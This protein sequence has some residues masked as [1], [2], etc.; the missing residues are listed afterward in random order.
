[1]K[2]KQWETKQLDDVA[3]FSSGGTPSKEEPNYWEGDYP[4]ISAKDMKS[5][6]IKD[7]GLKLTHEGLAVAKI[8]KKGSVLVL[9]RGMTLLK[10]LPV[11]YVERDVAFNQDI[12]ALVAK[13]GVSGLF[14][15][16]ALIANKNRILNLVN[17]AGHGTGRLDTT[18]LKEFPIDLPPLLEQCR[19]AEVLGVWDESIDLL[20]RLIGR[21]R[22]RKQGL[23]QQLLT[24]KN[25]VNILTAKESQFFG[26]IQIHWEEKNFS[27]V[28]ELVSRKNSIKVPNVLT[29]SSKNGFVTQEDRFS[30]VIA[31]ANLEN[32][33][34]LRKGEFAYNKGNSKSYECGCIFLMEEYQEA[35]IPNV[36]ICFRAKIEVN[37][38][39]YK[40]FFGADLLKKQLRRI[41]NS[42]VR[43][44]GL[45]NLKT[46]EFFQMK[47]LVCPLAEQEKIAAVLSA[48]DEEISTL[49]KQLAA[50]KQQKL[51]LMQQ[52]LTGSIRI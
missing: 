20:E 39:Y 34:L 45:L 7:A 27:D 23:M 48:A 3:T 35:A 5:F 37:E 6:S 14:L 25:K 41:I 51:G 12:K 9:V 47:V 19:I 16:Y 32:Y 36:Y 50:Y 26:K 17:V 30:K 2:I 18:L 40:F 4:W 52:L 22:S 43:N 15:A 28:F 21:V 31:G 24:G 1:M 49:E 11:G 42:G 29:I 46:E 44:D 33:T 38:F 8:A 13:S 10:D